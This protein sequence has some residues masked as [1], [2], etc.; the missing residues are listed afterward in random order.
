MC[1]SG[2]W[3]RNSDKDKDMWWYHIR[4]IT[5]KQVRKIKRLPRYKRSW[6]FVVYYNTIKREIKRRPGIKRV[7]VWWK[8]KISRWGIYTSHI[9]WVVRGTGTNKD[10]DE[11]NRREVCEHFTFGLG[12]WFLN[13]FS[14]L[15]S[16]LFH[17]PF[18]IRHK[19]Y[20]SQKE[21]KIKIRRRHV[22][23]IGW[24]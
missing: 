8:T 6:K 9:H 15:Y 12:F 19:L 4:W 18:Y 1:V 17:V 21:I 22:F 11:V 14:E 5:K 20:N 16:G 23:P 13:F 24:L 7:S 10:R 2:K 3:Y